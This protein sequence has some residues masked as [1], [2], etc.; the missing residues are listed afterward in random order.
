MKMHILK[1]EV[2]V[3]FDLETVFEFF[4]RPEN[5]QKVT[6]DILNFSIMTPSP[7]QMHNGAVFDYKI[8]LLGV[9]MHWRSI[10]TRYNPPYEFVDIQLKGPYKFWHH[11]HEFEIVE[12]GVLVRDTVTYDVGWGFLGWILNNVFIRRQLEWI[13]S[14]REHVAELIQAKKEG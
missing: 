7:V 11:H 12:G 13:F 5:L 1:K 6:P 14:K 4:N 2:V 10:I 8:S 3:P 9:P